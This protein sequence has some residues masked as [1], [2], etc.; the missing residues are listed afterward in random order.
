MIHSGNFIRC[1]LMVSFVLLLSYGTAQAPNDRY[2][3]SEPNPRSICNARNTCGSA[4]T[5]CTV[6]VKRDDYLWCIRDAW[7]P[8]CEGEQH[9]LFEGRYNDYL[10]EHS[11]EYRLP[12]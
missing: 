5:P 10:E 2:A 4:S 7:Y 1:S 8:R 12:H 3:C 9:I 6:D 11:E